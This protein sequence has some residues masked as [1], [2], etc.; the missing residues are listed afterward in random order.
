MGDIMRY[1]ILEDNTLVVTPYKDKFLKYILDNKILK[2]VKFI[3]LDEFI[4]L[5]FFNYDEKTIYYVMK[6]YNIGYY[7]SLEYIKSLYFI[8]KEIDNEKVIFLNELKNKLIKNNL[9]K[10]TKINYKNILIYGYNYIDSYF[11][12]EFEKYDVKYID[13]VYKNNE[14]NTVY[15]LNNI[16][17]EVLFV[18][19]KIIDLIN[20]NVDINN[21]KL[22]N[23]NEDYRK[24]IRKVFSLSN[25]PFEDIDIYLY[26]LPIIKKYLENMDLSVFEVKDEI[27]EKLV[28]VLNKY[29]WT[30]LNDVKELIIEDL[31]KVPINKQYT[32]IVKEVNIDDINEND[33]VFLLN[34]HSISIP[35]IYKDIDYLSDDLKLKLGLDTTYIKNKNERIEIINKLKNISNLVISCNKN[36]HISNL[37]E[38]IEIKNYDF[39]YNY[40]KKNNNYNLGIMLDN[41]YKY[42]DF[43]EKINDIYTDSYKKYNNQFTNIN[44]DEL[45]KYLNN[46]LLL[47]YTKLDSYYKCGFKYYINYI[48]KIDKFEETFKIYLGNISH[49]ILSKCF[50]DDFNFDLEFSNYLEDN[51]RDFS[52]KELF[53]INKLKKELLFIINEIKEQNKYISLNN[54]LYEKKI[55][56]K[57]NNK[58]FEGIIDKLIYDDNNMAIIDYKT[59]IQDINLDYIKYGIGLQLP[60]YVYLSKNIFKDKNIAG[61]Y[62]QHILNNEGVNNT[63]EDKKNSLKLQGYSNSNID[64]LKTL[65]NTYEDSKLIKSLKMTSKGFSSYSKLINNEEINDLYNLSKIKIDECFN[66]ILNGEF[67]INPKVIDNKN[68]SCNYCK[69]KDLC[70]KEEKDNIYLGGEEDELY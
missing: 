33:Y 43:N 27:Y 38:N 32:N 55:V 6:N 49:Y 31:K 2:N 18:S 60:I 57:N 65:D 19:E 45:L 48:L 51:K 66:H 36:N 42:G 70:F 34:Y 10:K 54:S 64:I 52:N 11:K 13:Y 21:I 67:I 28:N 40:S 62:L 3:S 29:V 8:N 56:I 15:Q 16:Y 14:I 44:K 26:E 12:K 7:S 53:F 59:G 20:N 22:L 68:I 17:S 63:L 25:I 58:D 47:S 4:K 61:F 50:N 1:D 46:Y 37:F 41:Y 30:N 39:K 5:V 69:Y 35:K 24:E 9:L 23:L